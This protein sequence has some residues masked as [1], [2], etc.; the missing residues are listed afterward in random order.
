MKSEGEKEK[1]RADKAEALKLKVHKDLGFLLS[2]KPV[3]I[4]R[5]TA[6]YVLEEG[7][8]EA[9]ANFKEDAFEAYYSCLKYDYDGK[10]IEKVAVGKLASDRLEPLHEEI[11]SMRVK[12]KAWFNVCDQPVHLP[13]S[14]T[15]LLEDGSIVEGEEEVESGQG[16]RTGFHYEITLD[17]IEYRNSEKI[18]IKRKINE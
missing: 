7:V 12:E 13:S 18:K 16:A 6:K 5:R 15:E 14:R 9:I 11:M 10:S 3:F 17:R 4:S 1:S 8:D 2:L